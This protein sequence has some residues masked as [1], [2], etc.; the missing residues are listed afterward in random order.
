MKS[1][2]YFTVLLILFYTVFSFPA[3]EVGTIP[4]K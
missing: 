2:K 4:I 3:E 1:L